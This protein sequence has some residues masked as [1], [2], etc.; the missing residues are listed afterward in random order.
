MFFA[1]IPATGWADT[2]PCEKN[3]TVKDGFFDKKIYKT[4]QD[5]RALTRQTI[6]KRAY[7]Y[8]V[9][10]GW[11]IN[12]A[13]METGVIIASQSG[14]AGKVASLNIFIENSGNYF[15]GVPGTRGV[16]G[17]FRVTMTFSV[18]DGLDA[19]ED[20]VRN[21]YCHALAEIKDGTYVAK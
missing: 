2:A 17:A 12:L 9:K 7:A 13:D 10:G 6:F 14:G 3:F 19:H 5:I 11:V 16:T 4:W 8:L 18:P 21:D 15:G 1:I 20:M